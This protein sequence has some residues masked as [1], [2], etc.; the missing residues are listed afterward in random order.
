[1][2]NKLYKKN[3]DELLASNDNSDVYYEKVALCLKERIDHGL[4]LD[5][6]ENQMLKDFLASMVRCKDLDFDEKNKLSSYVIT[7]MRLSKKI[8]EKIP[9]SKKLKKMTLD[10]LL[11][12]QDNLYDYY[13][14]YRAFCTDIKTFLDIQNMKDYKITNEEIKEL[15]SILDSINRKD[16]GYI[17]IKD[18]ISK[19]LSKLIRFSKPLETKKEKIVQPE[20]EIYKMSLGEV[21]LRQ[22]ELAQYYR[23][24]LREFNKY[25]LYRIKYRKALK[26]DEIKELNNFCQ[27]L[28]TM[29]NKEL[30]RTDGLIYDEAVKLIVISKNLFSASFVEKV[31]KDQLDK[32]NEIELYTYVE[33]IIKDA[34]PCLNKK[35]FE[36][37]LDLIPDDYECLEKIKKLLTRKSLIGKVDRRINIIKLCELFDTLPPEEYKKNPIPYKLSS[38]IL[39]RIENKHI[40][41]IDDSSSPDLDGAFSVEKEG[42]I[43]RFNVYITDVPSFLIDNEEMMN[44]AYKRAVSM[45]STL[46][47]QKTL[48]Y[49]MI[50]PVISH[51]ALSLKK[52]NNRNVIT[53]SYCIDKEGKVCLDKITRNSILVNDNIDPREIKYYKVEPKSE[54]VLH[55]YF[56]MCNL[57]CNNSD[58]KNLKQLSSEGKIDMLQSLPSIVTNY[59]IGENSDLV[60]YREK[61][62]YTKESEEKYTHSVSPLR[63]FVSDINLAMYLSQLGIINCPDKYIHY[64][65]DHLDEIIEHINKQEELNLCFATSHCDFARYFKK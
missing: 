25:L 61:G 51:N 34:S 1:M 8:P 49:N 15:T 4:L 19:S 3:L 44:Y 26:D 17:A 27:R 36:D 33:C 42:D 39:P 64:V 45:Y 50:P 60:I 46:D 63:R 37:I 40:I 21:L 58:K 12:R 55:T 28:R 14:N 24:Y 2:G 38:E 6:N 52:N 57:V 53:F 59:H 47:S 56:E 54:E 5:E 32:L 23:K 11:S 62:L 29:E 31:T 22:E 13:Y 20:P 10:E 7:L 48:I 9:E 41:T 16:K 43:Y 18:E 35:H 65:E 30:I